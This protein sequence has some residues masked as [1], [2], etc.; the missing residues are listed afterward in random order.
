MAF[1]QVGAN[2]P[3]I[4]IFFQ[5]SHINSTYLAN[6]KKISIQANAKNTPTASDEQQCK[7]EKLVPRWF[8]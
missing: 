1:F 3:S 6:S 7:A 8:I 4:F 5:V 2:C